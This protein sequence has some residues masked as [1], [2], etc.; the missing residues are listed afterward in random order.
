MSKT[1]FD[2]SVSGRTLTNDVPLHKTAY[3]GGINGIV[4]SN[5]VAD[6]DCRICARKM[7][8]PALQSS[9]TFDELDSL[10]SLLA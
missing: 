2:A 1:H 9:F 10:H 7:V 8:A 5:Q 3:S 4:S 6:V